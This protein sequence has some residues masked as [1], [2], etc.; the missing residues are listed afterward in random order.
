MGRLKYKLEVAAGWMG[1]LGALAVAGFFLWGAVLVI[2][3]NTHKFVVLTAVCAIVCAVFGGIA[4]SGNGNILGG[5][6]VGAL[7]GV[8]IAVLLFL[9]GAGSGGS[10][11]PIPMR[12][13]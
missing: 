3:D 11:A 6:I 5:I 8:F 9:F 13:P 2:S 12:D 4:V 7:V 10:P 1:C